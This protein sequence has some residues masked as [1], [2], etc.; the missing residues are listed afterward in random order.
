[1]DEYVGKMRNRIDY[2]ANEEKRMVN[3]MDRMTDLM[4]KRQDIMVAK[5]SE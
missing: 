2:L 4:G 5:W 3:K 1:V